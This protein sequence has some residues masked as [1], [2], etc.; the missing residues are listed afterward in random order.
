MKYQ[1]NR[2]TDKG[3]FLNFT[4]ATKCHL[5]RGL[6]EISDFDYRPTG[7][8]PEGGAVGDYGSVREAL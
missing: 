5:G 3:A 2:G 1:I 7:F 8:S 4:P 6:L